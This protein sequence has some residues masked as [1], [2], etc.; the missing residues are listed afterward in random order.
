MIFEDF[1]VKLHSELK[2]CD[3]KAAFEM[4]VVIV[5][6]TDAASTKVLNFNSNNIADIEWTVIKEYVYS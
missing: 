2:D 1:N 3:Y 6:I 5:D 4:A